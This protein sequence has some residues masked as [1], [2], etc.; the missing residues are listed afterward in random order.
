MQIIQSGIVLYLCRKH[1][2]NG[3]HK[4]LYWC[5]FC[6]QVTHKRS[7]LKLCV[8]TMMPEII[9]NDTFAALRQATDGWGLPPLHASVSR[10]GHLTILHHADLERVDEGGEGWPRTGSDYHSPTTPPFMIL[11][12]ATIQGHDSTHES[13]LLSP[14]GAYYYYYYCAC[15]PGV[16]IET[17]R[18]C[19]VSVHR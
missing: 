9:H 8:C 5:R 6:K 10:G 4:T 17:V 16:S 1:I 15:L 14:C 19:T 11:R 3:T 12:I 18:S 13:I 7:V 2:E